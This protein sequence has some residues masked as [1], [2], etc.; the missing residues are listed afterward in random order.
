[1][2]A[3]FWDV[4]VKT[5]FS[6]SGG[7]VNLSRRGSFIPISN[8]FPALHF[9]NGQQQIRTKTKSVKQKFRES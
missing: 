6:V 7:K 3:K 5:N 4:G 8:P 9:R 1:M 2:R